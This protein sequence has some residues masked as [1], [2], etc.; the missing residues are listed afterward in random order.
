MTDQPAETIKGENLTNLLRYLIDS[1]HL[2]KIM[3]P[4]S[5]FCWIT[6]LSGIQKEGSSNCLLIDGVSGFDR[7]LSQSKDR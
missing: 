3:I 5:S 6:L 7:A 4:K 2:C 1:R